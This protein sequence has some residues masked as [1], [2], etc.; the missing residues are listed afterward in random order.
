MLKIKA[1]GEVLSQQGPW[2]PRR[3][4]RS[5][6]GGKASLD[7]LSLIQS[8]DKVVGQHLAER[9]VPLK[10]VRGTLT[11]LAGHSAYSQQLSFMQEQIKQKIGECYPS[12]ARKIERVSFQADTTYFEAQREDLR[13]AAAQRLAPKVSGAEAAK[14]NPG[15]RP[16]QASHGSFH[17]Y[18]PRYRRL[19][20]EAER[21]FVDIKDGE[22]KE[23]L[24]A[25][26]LQFEGKK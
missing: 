19:R 24:V 15:A 1:L 2:V 17:P 22:L 12:L 20:R 9:T 16:G 5:G 4:K 21:E 6:R 11:I 18:D 26:Y 14:G 13:K 7:F 25:L 8:W 3:P 23:S 10:L